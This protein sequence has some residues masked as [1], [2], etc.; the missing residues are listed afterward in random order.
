MTFRNLW[1]PKEINERDG[2]FSFDN[3][4]FVMMQKYLT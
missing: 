1:K 2:F 4:Y 3:T